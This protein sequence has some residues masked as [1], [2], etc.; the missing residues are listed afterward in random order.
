MIR[1]QVHSFI[2]ITCTYK[3]FMY[4]Q[5]TLFICFPCS[6]MISCVPYYIYIDTYWHALSS[7]CLCI[8]NLQHFPMALYYG[9]FL[10]FF[11]PIGKFFCMSLISQKILAISTL[12]DSMK[13]WRKPARWSRVMNCSVSDSLYQTP[14]LIA[15]LPDSQEG[16]IDSL[17]EQSKI[18]WEQ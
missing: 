18:W 5:T 12:P 10:T 14:F 17:N 8:T 16:T 3:T 15:R 9:S 2:L 6:W 1:A 11:C 4:S 13:I 7:M